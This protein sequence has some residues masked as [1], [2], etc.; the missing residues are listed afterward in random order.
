MPAFG[1][2][3]VRWRVN[4]GGIRELEMLVERGLVACGE[5]VADA[6]RANI[7]PHRVTGAV[8][9]SIYVNDSLVEE[10][11]R[12]VVFVAAASG[13]SFWVHEGTVDTPYIPF[14]AEAL[15]SVA[16]EFP[17]LIKQGSEAGM[18]GR[19][20]RAPAQRPRLSRPGSRKRAFQDLAEYVA[21]VRRGL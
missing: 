11:P 6:A 10:W 21:E 15:D 1:Q 16:R 14:L 3:G 18:L 12:P 4:P 9:D 8:E 17:R 19:L 5:A 7:A 2:L 20:G 13:D